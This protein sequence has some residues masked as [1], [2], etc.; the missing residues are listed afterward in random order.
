MISAKALMDL[1]SDRS[2]FLITKFSFPVSSKMSDLAS[3]ALSRSLHAM[4]IRAPENQRRKVTILDF[5]YNIHSKGLVASVFNRLGLKDILRVSIQ[6][7]DSWKCELS[8]W[9][10]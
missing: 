4:M 2:S 10:S 8:Y 1:V 5:K 6:K 9:F 7:M 3:S